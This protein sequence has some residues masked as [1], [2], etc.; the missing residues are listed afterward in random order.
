MLLLAAMSILRLY[1]LTP[2]DLF[3]KWEA[4]LLSSSSSSSSK[5]DAPAFTLGNLREL[6]KEIQLSANANGAQNKREA[7]ISTPGHPAGTS[8]IKK[9][10]GRAALDGMCAVT[11]F[12]H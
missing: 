5:Q 8:R 11:N 9:L 1:A 4:F 3:F 2:A 10:A 7:G 12:T 6:K